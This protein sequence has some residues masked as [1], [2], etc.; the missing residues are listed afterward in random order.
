MFLVNDL[1]KIS[2]FTIW[3][4][5]PA[6]NFTINA[7]STDSRNIPADAI[8]IPIVGEKFNGH[9]FLPDAVKSAK[10]CVTAE[11]PSDE[12]IALAEEN[13]C[14]LARVSDTL[15]FYHG[16]AKHYR[17]QFRGLKVIAITGSCGKT[18][19]KEIIAALLDNGEGNV[20][21]TIGNTNNHIGVP[22]NLFRLTEQHEFAVLELGTN[23]FGEIKTLATMVRPDISVITNIGS[24]HLEFLRDRDGVALEKSSIFTALREGSTAIL[25]ASE[26][27]RPIMIK[28]LA[29]LHAV[30]FGS[31]GEPADYHGEQLSC[32]LTKSTV[33]LNNLEVA[34]PLLGEHQAVNG[35]AAMAV[36]D[37]LNLKLSEKE[38][39]H[40]LQQISMPK[41]RSEIVTGELHTWINDAYNANTESTIAT[42]KWLDQVT[43]EAPLIVVLG[44]IL[45]LGAQALEE[46]KRVL[47]Y[48][49]NYKKAEKTIVIG[50]HYNEALTH[51]ELENQVLNFSS[52]EA[53][54][55]FLETE[56][57]EKKVIVLK[58]SRGI[59]LEKLIF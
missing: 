28:R 50:Q 32:G 15:N 12:L 2:A 16:L 40:R 46:H 29:K 48:I 52:I 39:V 34:W 1:E 51:L 43:L 35:A 20:L 3:S 42:L 5:K 25:P 18:S 38:I 37:A 41:M 45:E 57:N 9:T 49:S 47:K 21:K 22:Q 14:A 13:N 24:S 56:F 36:L 7:V 11:R 17:D 31:K 55:N 8:Y 33:K 23:H 59:G 26:A 44:D 53:A 19:T 10:V 27:S 30:T 58:G 4:V 6:D 54:K